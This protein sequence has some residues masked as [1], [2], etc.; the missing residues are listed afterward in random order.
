MLSYSRYTFD[1][2]TLL[3]RHGFRE[4]FTMQYSTTITTIV[5]RQRVKLGACK[6]GCLPAPIRMAIDQLSGSLCD[7]IT[8]WL[9]ELTRHIKHRRPGVQRQ[10]SLLSLNLSE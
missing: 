4:H 5:N 6:S 1:Q 10:V 3:D 8:V 9:A 7:D 2:N